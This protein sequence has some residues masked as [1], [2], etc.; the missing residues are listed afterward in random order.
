[1]EN[2]Y[3]VAISFGDDLGYIDYDIENKSAQESNIFKLHFRDIK[4]SL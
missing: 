1:M 2:T 4:T 3:S